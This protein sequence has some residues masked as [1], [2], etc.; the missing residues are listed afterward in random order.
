MDKWHR[1]ALRTRFFLVVGLLLLVQLCIVMTSQALLTSQDRLDRLQQYELP[2]ALEGIGSGIQAE[3]NSMI[4]GSQALANNP[5]ITQWVQQ[6][7]PQ[8]GF[9]QVSQTMVK[10]QSNLG[11]LG[12]FLAAND[13]NRMAYYHYEDGQLH[14][15]PLTQSNPDD[16]WYF[17]YLSRQPE[18]ELNL[19]SNDFSGNDL[20]MFIN[21]SS[22]ELN[23]AGRPYVVAGGV[24][25]LAAVAKLI[26][27]YQIGANGTVLMVAANG[28]VDVGPS[29]LPQDL[30]LAQNPTIAPLIRQPST[31]V[32]VAKGDWLGRDSYIASYWLPSLQRYVVATVPTSEITADIRNNQ[33]LIAGLSLVL[34]L[35]GLLVL[36]PVTGALIRPVVR[37]REQIRQA[38]ETLDLSMQFKTR[39]QAEIGDLCAQMTHLMARLR[40]TMQEVAVVSNETEDLS[41]QLESG[42]QSTT[43]SFHEQQAALAQISATMEGIAEQVSTIAHSA[44]EAGDQSSQ[45]RDILAQSVQRLQI[46]VSAI[47]QLQTEMNANREEMSVLQHHG[48]EI[49]VVLDVIRGISEQTNLLALNAAIEAARAGEHGRGFAVVADEV[50]Q[51][52]QR[53]SDSTANIQGMIDTLRGATQ[54][55]A[56]QMQNSTEST[57]KGLAGL[58]ETHAKLDDMSHQLT[59]VFDRNAQIAQSTQDQEYSISEVHEGLQAL[60]TQGEVAATM[61]DQSSSATRHLRDRMGTLKEHMKVFTF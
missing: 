11:A 21:F 22:T 27:S 32:Q 45:G 57:E 43:R 23:A 37:L 9:E 51:L 48:D 58:H 28:Q 17:D 35:V 25:D 7:M 29:D 39:D 59:A 41:E 44:R 52:A 61:A 4:A 50:R 34:L 42:A 1:L 10:T 5:V 49:L 38:S 24:M 8:S 54:R 26:Q 40:G 46:S 55:M 47:E 18:Y 15:R 14:E 53:T 19:D 30:A 3:L 31:S 16:S 6:G 13:G 12:V 56:D 60:S 20:R 36:Y 33:L 2:L